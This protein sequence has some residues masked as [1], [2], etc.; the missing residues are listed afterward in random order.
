MSERTRLLGA[1]DM[2]APFARL[3]A[4]AYSLLTNWQAPTSELEQT[5]Q[6]MLTVLD[7]DLTAMWREHSRVHFTASLV[8]LSPDADTVALTLHGKAKRWFQFGG[9]FEA[10]DADVAAAALREGTEESGLGDLVL[11]P[12][13]IQ[14]DAHE[15]TS[16]FGHCAEHLDLRF[17]AR[18]T[19]TQLTRSDESDEVAW[20]PLDALPEDTE[21]SLRQAIS[22]AQDAIVRFG[23]CG[24]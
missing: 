6:R 7:A 11:I 18:A 19:S 16:A 20:W 24:S 12:R 9:H 8:V 23:E 22:L 17:A 13:L 4:D 21:D 5:R 2:P 14:V 3:H 1:G 15:L 10:T